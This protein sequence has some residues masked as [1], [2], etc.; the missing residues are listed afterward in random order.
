MTLP[1]FAEIW[2]RIWLRILFLSPTAQHTKARSCLTYFV[3]QFLWTIGSDFFYNKK[4]N[5][6]SN[7]IIRETPLELV[8][9]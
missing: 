4:D 9:I 1:L 3:L 2:I 6:D 7:P 5:V 8:T